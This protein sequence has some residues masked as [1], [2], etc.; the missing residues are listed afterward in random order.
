MTS[1]ISKRRFFLIVLLFSVLT[2]PANATSYRFFPTGSLA[3]AQ[4]LCLSRESYQPISDCQNYGYRIVNQCRL[5]CD[6]WESYATGVKYCYGVEWQFVWQP[7]NTC[8]MIEQYVDHYTY[9]VTNCPPETTYIGPGPTDCVASTSLNESGV[10][11]TS[12]GPENSST[13]ADGQE[14]GCS[15]S[16]SAALPLPAPEGSQR[17][18]PCDAANGNKYMER[19]DFVGGDGVPTFTRYYN[20]YETRVSSL[21]SGWTHNHS[22]RLEK[23]SDTILHI[24]R[25]SGRAESFAKNPDQT[26]IGGIGTRYRLTEDPATHELTLTHRDGSFEKYDPLGN[27]TVKSDSQ[28]RLTHYS[29]F[30]NRLKTVTGPYGHTL[31][32]TYLSSGL[33]GKIQIPS[34]KYLVFTY[35]SNNNQTSVTYPSDGTIPLKETYHYED[36]NFP[37]HLTGITDENNVRFATYVYDEA[38][39]TI[40]TEHAGGAE[41]FTFSYGENETIVTDA[42][43]YAETLTFESIAGIKKVKSVLSQTD[44]KTLLQSFDTAGRLKQITDPNNTVTK[45]AYNTAGQ[46]TAITEAFGKPEERE[47]TIGYISPDIDLP[48]TITYPSVLAGHSKSA[49][50]GYSQSGVNLP[51]S[52]TIGGY[53]PNGVTVQRTTAFSYDNDGRVLSMNGP[54]TDISDVTTFTYN[55]CSTGQGCGQLA[56]MTNALGQTTTFNSYDNN[57]RLTQF[58]NPAGTVVNLA[59][60]ARGQLITRTESHGALNRIW[61]YDYA[62]TGL[63]SKITDPDG[64]YVNFGYNVAH[65]LLSVT[66]TLGHSLQ[67]EYD[68]RGNR[69]VIDNKDV[70]NNLLT[71][72]QLLFDHR[73]R[74]TS[75]ATG[76]S[77]TQKLWDAVGNLLSETDANNHETNWTYDPFGNVKTIT[78]AL[79]DESVIDHDIADRLVSHDAPNGASTEFAY[80]DLGNLLKEI[81]A[82]RGTTE[83]AYDSAGNLIS[84]TDANNNSV[85]FV[86]DAL[87]RIKEIH[88]PNT[89]ENIVYVYDTCRIGELC[90]ADDASGLINFHHDDLGRVQE[91]VFDANNGSSYTTGYS[92]TEGDRLSVMTYPGGRQV[93]YGRNANGLIQSVTTTINGQPLNVLS[94]RLYRGDGQWSEETFGNGLI[95]TRLYDDRGLP[96]DDNLGG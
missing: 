11:I 47:T 12:I 63:P 42:D 66:D 35:S 10:N 50:F 77:T 45:Y 79:L 3:E 1:A 91:T 78:N 95:Q 70:S 62:K 56:T 15:G 86:Y 6:T 54:R 69:T 25:G 72:T 60:N 52:I 57:G 40:S 32:F 64:V 75:I 46:F 49:T 68:N 34:G 39:R 55:S 87:N 94:N 43:N 96:S 67:F 90:S 61:K 30:N 2:T 38:G 44:N 33:L 7:D 5:S 59:Y 23:V 76:I 9:P 21:G 58:T 13:R 80:D 17:G 28:G 29:Y 74:P 92:W 22:M 41:K 4:S 36:P 93:S 89:S 73:S 82:D 16:Q 20:S 81:S 37:H 18:N 85:S 53:K 27:L 31:N 84:S 71:H 24:V 88:Y 14:S 26:W 65:Q 19:E 51:T 8:D 83:Y 48:V